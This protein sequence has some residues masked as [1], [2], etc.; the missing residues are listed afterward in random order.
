MAIEDTDLSRRQPK[1]FYAT[2]T[3]VREANHALKQAGARVSP[4]QG[5]HALTI[6][7]AKEA[8]G[9]A[10]YTVTPVSLKPPP[11]IV[12]AMAAEIIG[13]AQVLQR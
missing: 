6:V 13:S 12:N 5:S 9:R 2:S 11:Q 7:I 8:S 4:T 10:F 1:E 3:I